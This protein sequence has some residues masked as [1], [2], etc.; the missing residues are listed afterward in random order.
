[1]R[2]AQTL[3]TLTS[4]PRRVPPAVHLA[5]FVAAAL[6]GAAAVASLTRVPYIDALVCATGAVTGGSLVP[7][8]TERLPPGGQV[9]IWLLM[10]AGG[11]TVTALGPLGYRIY[12]FH[13]RLKPALRRARRLGRELRRTAR[14]RLPAPGS[15]PLLAVAEQG[16]EAAAAAG[17]AA[18]ADACA[19][20]GTAAASEAP[21]LGTAAS[22]AAVLA[23]LDAADADALLAELSAQDEGLIAVAAAVAAYTTLWTLSVAGALWRRAALAPPNSALGAAL[24]ARRLPAP[25][26]GLFF[27]TSAFNNVGLSLFS[28]S[29]APLA[30]D[31]QA[32]IALSF[33]SLAGNTAWPVALRALLLAG[34]RAGERGARRRRVA[35]SAGSGRRWDECGPCSGAGAALARGAR[36]A[37]SHP[38]RCYHLLFPRRETGALAAA[39]AA[40]LS[41]QFAVFGAA[42]AWLPAVRAAQPGASSTARAAFALFTVVN[43]RS[44][45][46][47]LLDLNV[48]APVMLVL[49]SFMMY[50]SPYPLVALWARGDH[51][52]ADELFALV[53]KP[54]AAAPDAAVAGAAGAGASAGASAYWQHAGSAA[55]AAATPRS[56]LRFRWPALA[57]FTRGYLR[58]HVTWILLTF[59]LLAAAEAHLLAHPS[60][61]G[62]GRSPT[63]LFALLFESLSA[64]GTNGMSLGW[65]GAPYNLCGQFRTVSKLALVGLML[66]GRHRSMPRR[67]DPPLASRLAAVEELVAAAEA[68]LAARAPRPGGSGT[69][70]GGATGSGLGGALAARVG[71][72]THDGVAAALALIRGTTDAELAAMAAGSRQE[73][74]AA[75]AVALR[76]QRAERGRGARLAAAA[77]AWWGRRGAGAQDADADAAPTQQQPA[78]GGAADCAAV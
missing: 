18:D 38:Q 57:N 33:A 68:E 13:A 73:R 9:V 37:L 24:A 4:P 40:T 54:E 14:P 5:F 51:D 6:L 48:L 42:C 69:T 11:V 62:S 12:V 35:E 20:P 26:F 55:A 77:R 1:L 28:S 22:A 43:S 8:D 25:W 66:L 75:V 34:A 67:V 59:L 56:Q 36:Y 64:Y 58:R 21:P 16:E 49:F 63:S 39:L 23:A 72:F 52:A 65:P 17:A 32:L 60:E 71:S 10:A 76:R 78:E 19:P 2:I 70:G 29:A 27:A 15:A 53:T 47:T 41:L 61:D 46:F 44:T 3:L 30:G 7:F 74:E 31:P 50:W 45:G